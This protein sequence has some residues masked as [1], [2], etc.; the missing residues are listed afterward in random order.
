MS[1]TIA[2]FHCY[3]GIAGDMAFGSL[4]DAKFS[5]MVA[6]GCGAIVPGSADIF[7]SVLLS[8]RETVHN[9]FLDEDYG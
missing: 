1:R 9:A 5:R 7:E 6:F 8:D 4:I 3:A 2:W